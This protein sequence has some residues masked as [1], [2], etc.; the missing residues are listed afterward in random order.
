LPAGFP[1][2]AIFLY[3]M[4]KA[5]LVSLLREPQKIGAESALELKKLIRIYP[6]CQALYALLAKAQPNDEQVTQAAARTLDRGR[7]R[8][9]L[10]GQAAE[11]LPTEWQKLAIST[12]NDYDLFDKLRGDGPMSP[13]LAEPE[14]NLAE[15]VVDNVA[16]SLPPS[17]YPADNQA[18]LPADGLDFLRDPTEPLPNP[19]NL[20]A[21]WPANEPVSNEVANP[22]LL[23]EELADNE[24]INKLDDDWL[25]DFEE[26]YK[27]I[28]SGQMKPSEISEVPLEA[29]LDLPEL[30]AEPQLAPAELTPLPPP[31]EPTDE[32]IDQLLNDPDYLKLKNAAPEVPSD[33]QGLYQ[34]ELTP[35]VPDTE[36]F[37]AGANL[38]A[39]D[40]PTEAELDHVNNLAPPPEPSLEIAAGPEALFADP[41]AEEPAEP[42]A[43]DEPSYLAPTLP[44]PPLALADP[45]TSFLGEPDGET[46]WDD[47]HAI[48]KE[49]EDWGTVANPALLF[50]AD[51]PEEQLLDLADHDLDDVHEVRKDEEIAYFQ[52]LAEHEA[53]QRAELAQRAAELERDQAILR[54]V[55]AALDQ[56]PAAPVLATPAAE[57]PSG[58]FFDFI[59]PEHEGLKFKPVTEAP[60]GNP[61]LQSTTA[62][63]EA[64]TEEP[65]GDDLSFFD[66]PTPEKTPAEPTEQLEDAQ[67]KIINEFI[68]LQ[69]SLNM[70]RVKTLDENNLPDLSMPSTQWHPDL[71]SETLAR[72]YAQQGK[73][74]IAT[75]MYHQLAQKFPERAAEFLTKADSLK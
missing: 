46:D 17:L 14:L 11:P 5:E 47:V 18:T 10:A 40:G 51:M 53:E 1:G 61:L 16:D 62:A 58:N 21:H 13:P 19:E 59:E 72:I 60:L 27:D 67:Q 35:P 8:Q 65:I 34:D 48:R 52:N 25:R 70:E 39:P 43:T 50:E 36:I 41:F 12:D 54:E 9:L 15:P 31:E 74:S 23:T 44:E 30:A 68:R 56:P 24:P 20:V 29:P 55:S 42:V 38:A 4:K 32:Q 66:Q 75:E 73:L 37:G 33:W 45:P 63:P 71:V 6:Y 64:P 22:E 7:L 3:A 57:A 26:R 49:E 2:P 28:L 69:P